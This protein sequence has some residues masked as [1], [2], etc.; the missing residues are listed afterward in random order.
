MTTTKTIIF[1]PKALEDITSIVEHITENNPNA[2]QSFRKRLE[3]T[4]SLLAD[5]PGI[6]TLRNFDNPY[7][8]NVRFLPLKQF[9]KYLVFYQM[10]DDAMHI[11]RI[12]HGARDLPALFGTDEQP[13]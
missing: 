8:A 2:A 12:V 6:G 11:I 5:M 9:E 10:R 13:E 3:Q 1:N 4:C 7:L